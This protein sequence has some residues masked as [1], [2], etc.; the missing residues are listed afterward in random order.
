M[1]TVYQ[2]NDLRHGRRVALKV[3]R[4][5]LAEA[6]GPEERFLGTGGCPSAR[7]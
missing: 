3:L 4:P 6:L 2:A 5:E 7:R 1:A